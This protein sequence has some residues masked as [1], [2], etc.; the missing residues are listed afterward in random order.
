MKS[1]KLALAYT[2]AWQGNITTKCPVSLNI[3]TLPMASILWVQGSNPGKTPHT[4]EPFPVDN[5]HNLSP[6]MKIHSHYYK[7]DKQNLSTKLP[8]R[9]QVIPHI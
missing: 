7:I 8:Y 2:K 9:L 4:F 5:G 6:E 3:G 1:S